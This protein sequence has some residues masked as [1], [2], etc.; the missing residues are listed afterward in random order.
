MKPG[1]EEL[2]SMMRSG[3]VSYLIDGTVYSG[4][5]Q[6]FNAAVDR[7]FNGSIFLIKRRL[8]AGAD[9]WSALAKP[10]GDKAQSGAQ[11]RRKKARAE[12]QEIIAA[13][14]ARKKTGNS[15]EQRTARMGEARRLSIAQAKHSPAHR[16]DKAR[17]RFTR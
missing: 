17:P 13:L 5:R 6:V 4:F 9:T 2:S 3:A 15:D 14:D 12:M 11:K 7:G 1:S 10:V 16:I 8:K